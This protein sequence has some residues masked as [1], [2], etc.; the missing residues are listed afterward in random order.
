MQQTRAAE[1]WPQRILLRAE[2]SL[3]RAGA[4]AVVPHRGQIEKVLRLDSTKFS[5]SRV[6]LGS[7]TGSC[8]VVDQAGE[9]QNLPLA[10]QLLC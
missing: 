3:R 8:D 2:I 4:F 9:S 6:T 10:D 5:S 1:P 7:A